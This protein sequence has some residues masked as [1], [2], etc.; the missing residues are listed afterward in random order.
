MRRLF[1][2]AC[3]CYMPLGAR[4]NRA[5]RLMCVVYRARG[6]MGA[7]AGTRVRVYID[8]VYIYFKA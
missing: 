4:V 2:L 6:I 5:A 7:G 1:T 8:I 3:V